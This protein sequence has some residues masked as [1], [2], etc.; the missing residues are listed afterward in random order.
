MRLILGA[1]I[2][3]AVALA[4]SFVAGCSCQT[5]RE[6]NGKTVRTSNFVID[7]S[8]VTSETV[9]TAPE[10][11]SIRDAIGIALVSAVWFAAGFAAGRKSNATKS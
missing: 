10:R 5:Y 6:V 8:G 4:P 9:E 7:G 3:V 2:R 11:H 1:A